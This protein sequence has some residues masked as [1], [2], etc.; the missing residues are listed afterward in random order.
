VN[1]WSIS[2]LVI[3]GFYILWLEGG[4]SPDRGNCSLTFLMPR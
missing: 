2:I 1:I 3:G 4:Y